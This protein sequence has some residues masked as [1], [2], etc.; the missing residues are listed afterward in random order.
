MPT[1]IFVTAEDGSKSV[2][3]IHFMVDEFDPTTTPG[4]DNVCITSLP[5]G[6]WKFTTN[7]T[8]VVL[9]LV[10]LDGK[11]LLTAPLELVNPNVP[12]ICSDEAEGFV[13]DAAIDNVIAYYFVHNM[14][15]VISS[16]KFR[17]S[18]Q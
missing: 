4:A 12:N 9:Y 6:S 13:Y 15:T 5:D 8:N 11:V 17:V 10:T 1:E 14:K 2:Y 7:C 3:R 16:G 18:H